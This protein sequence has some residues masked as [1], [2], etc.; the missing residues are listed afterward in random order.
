M[1]WNA[2]NLVLVFLIV[3][4]AISSIY[5]IHLSRQT[6]S[7]L[8]A[9]HQRS[10]AL[11]VEWTQL[12]LEQGAWASYSRVEQLAGERLRMERPDP[13]RVQVIEP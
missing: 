1:R 5:L 10:D 4:S 13:A 11:H 7:E 9:L 12:L 3:L 6:L 8:Q 2:I